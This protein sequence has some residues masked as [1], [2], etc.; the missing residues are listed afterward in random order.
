MTEWRKC[1]SCKL[2]IPFGSKYWVC[3]VT[4]CQKKVAGLIF[5]SVDC[6]DAHVP[7]LRHKESWAI[8]RNAPSEAEWQGVLSGRMKDPTYPEREREK[9]PEPVMEPQKSAASSTP[10]VI[11]RRKAT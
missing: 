9:P 10:A 2:T 3:N 4:T 8:E 5:C 11:L 7:V 1:T 6:W